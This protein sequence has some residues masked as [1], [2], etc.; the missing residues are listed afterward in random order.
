MRNPRSRTGSATISRSTP[1]TPRARA[2]STP[3][4][5]GRE[6]TPTLLLT[7]R[8]RRT[9]RILTMP[10]IYGE[11]DGAYVVIASK[12]GAPTHP[13]WFH[14]L[15]AEPEVRIQVGAEKMTAVAR[16][17]D[18]EERERL[19]SQMAELYPPYLKYQTRTD[20]LIPVVVLDPS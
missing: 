7:T 5:G 10:L 16:V 9:G 17:A 15:T 13:G 20:R 6:D 4:S 14:N 19:W 8:G 1:G 3:A 18:G 12:G 11:A 2:C